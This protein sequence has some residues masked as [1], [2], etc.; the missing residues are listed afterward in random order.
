MQ[1]NTLSENIYKNHNCNIIAI[2]NILIFIKLI[3]NNNKKVLDF[4]WSVC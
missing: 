2:C 3:T 4:F 1:K